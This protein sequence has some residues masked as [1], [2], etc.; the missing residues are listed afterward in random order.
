MEVFKSNGRIESDLFSDS[1]FVA[2]VHSIID[3]HTSTI[4][5]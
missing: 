3:S 5:P 4:L 2:L 1:A